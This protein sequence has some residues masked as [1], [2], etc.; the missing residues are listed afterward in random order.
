MIRR[1][2]ILSLFSAGAA[3][4]M[5]VSCAGPMVTP[6]APVAGAV[7]PTATALT[8]APSESATTPAPPRQTV[9]PRPTTSTATPGQPAATAT[10][11]PSQ[12][13][14]A[15]RSAAKEF[16]VPE[17]ILLAVGYNESR[18]EQHGGQPSAEGGYGIMHLTEIPGDNAPASHT[19]TAAAKLLGVTPDVLKTDPTQNVRGGAALLAQYAKDTVGKVPTNNPS[20]WY[21]AVAK[22]RGSSVIGVDF[23]FA[24]NVYKT[25]LAGQSLTTSGGELVELPPSL[26]GPNLR[27]ADPL[28][29]HQSGGRAAQCPPNLSCTYVPARAGNYSPTGGPVHYIVIHDTESSFTSAITTFQDAQKGTSANYI[30]RGDGQVVQMVPDGATAY[31]AGNF[32]IN[33]HAIGIEHEGIA[34]EG[35]TW[36]SE[37]LYETSATL[38][39]Y[40]AAQYDVPLDRAHIIGHDNVPGFNPTSLPGMH[41][42]PGPFWDWAHYMALLGAPIKPSTDPTPGI[43]TIAPTFSTNLQ[44]VLPQCDPDHPEKPCPDFVPLQPSNLVQLHTAP[45][46]DAPLISDPALAKIEVPGSGTTEIDDWG[47]TAVTGQKFAVAETRGDWTAIYFGGQ[48]A[49]FYN[50]RGTNTLP[51]SGSLI[52]PRPGLNSIPVYGV[53]G[54]GGTALP[55]R[56]PAG[57]SYV[58]GD[59]LGGYYEIFFNHRV[60]FVSAN[61]VDELTS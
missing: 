7:T 23:T 55:Y 53:A 2:L 30:V 24:D 51:A 10:T 60:A 13:Q 61:E 31:H 15:F 36:Y 4:T 9:T 59:N 42:D 43:V 3:L 54:G 57:Q 32:Y 37:T 28:Y 6:T 18:W 20:D 17:T 29:L 38:V 27:T 8:S 39:R 19:L 41:W 25:I 33:S 52:T 5:L 47:D 26:V 50:P 34:V 14:S 45:S 1:Q 11:E 21:G 44:M 40:L 35:A 22:Y 49:W 46:T 12:L 48:K 58:V 56:I 16:G